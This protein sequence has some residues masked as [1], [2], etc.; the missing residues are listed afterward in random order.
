MF[1]VGFWELVLCA[2]VA[3]VVLGPERMPVAVRSV[4]HW[5]RIAR[6]TLN[7]VKSEFEH[8][9][10]LGPLKPEQTPDLQP[11]H[12]A[13]AEPLPSSQTAVATEIQQAIAELKDSADEGKLPLIDKATAAETDAPLKL[14]QSAMDSRLIDAKRLCCNYASL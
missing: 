8:E 14:Q 7:A 10:A 6:S 1:D 4:A 11:P 13:A 5:V 9:L 2:I 12:I 3:L